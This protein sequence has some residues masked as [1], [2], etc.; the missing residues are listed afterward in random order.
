MTSRRTKAHHP[1]DG[2]SGFNPFGSGPVPIEPRNA[3]DDPQ[4]GEASEED[5][6]R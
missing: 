5:G 1:L 3:D 6:N 2:D 4:A